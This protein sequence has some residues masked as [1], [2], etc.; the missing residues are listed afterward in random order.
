MI[1]TTA[2][3]VAG[4]M[5][6]SAGAYA[7]ENPFVGTWKMNKE[8]SHIT[9]TAIANQ[10]QLLVIAPY[11]ENGWTRVQIDVKDPLQSGREEHY[12]AKYDGKPYQT[13][14]GDPRH[15]SLTRIDDRTLEQVTL[16]DGKESS[17]TRVSI[18]A[19]GKTMTTLGN[20]VN[21]RGDP[22]K[23]SLVIYDRVE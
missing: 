18:S 5:S 12:S 7:A 10:N 14:G 3:I 2:I 23:D 6:L 22:Y 8:K 20:G 19:D 13:N 1:R 16:R 11:G 17:R 21:G 4:L 9:N 15:I